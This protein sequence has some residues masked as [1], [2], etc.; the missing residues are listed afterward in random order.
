MTPK[1]DN[2]RISPLSISAQALI[3][4]SYFSSFILAMS[5]L[6]K[7]FLLKLFFSIDNFFLIV[8]FKSN[9]LK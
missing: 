6:L 4:T 1:A 7:I 5:S 2:V 9:F 8:F 3:M